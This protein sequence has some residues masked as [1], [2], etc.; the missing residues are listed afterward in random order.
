[1]SYACIKNAW[2]LSNIAW[3]IGLNFWVFEIGTQ[4]PTRVSDAF[5]VCVLGWGEG[6]GANAW[7]FSG[8]KHFVSVKPAT[9]LDCSDV[10]TQH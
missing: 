5:Y 8:T 9:K 3:D 6:R 10:L 7:M 1:M 4:S 2:T